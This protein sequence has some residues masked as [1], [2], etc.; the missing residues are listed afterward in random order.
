MRVQSY[1]FSFTYKRTIFKKFCF[2]IKEASLGIEPKSKEPESFILSVELRSLIQLKECKD[3]IFSIRNEIF[4]GVGIWELGFGSWD[5]GVGIRELGFGSWELGF[6]GPRSLFPF[7]CSHFPV[8]RSQKKKNYCSFSFIIT[9]MAP[10]PNF[11][12]EAIL[13]LVLS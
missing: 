10:T 12:I 4:L 13:L 3:N 5:S 9:S 1:I 8:P 7:P 6:P 11:T 2:V